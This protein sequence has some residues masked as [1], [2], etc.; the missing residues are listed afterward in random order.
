MLVAALAGPRVAARRSPRTVCQIGLIAV[1][2]GAIVMLAT[3]DATLRDTGFKVAL[4]LVGV[5]AGLLASQLGNVIMSSVDPSKTSETGG[6]QGTA[7]NLGASVGT[8]LIGAV[9]IVGLTNGFQS[10]I[11]DNPQLPESVRETIIANT[12]RGIDIAPVADVQ[13]LAVERGLPEDQAKAVADDYG[14]SQ[15]EALRKSLGAVALVALIA[16]WFTR[17]LPHRT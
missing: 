8:A 15:L 2:A 14:D 11:A 13:K 16:L 9:L 6:L 10:R 17:R 5:G 7:Q 12:T 4:V 3:L 1:S